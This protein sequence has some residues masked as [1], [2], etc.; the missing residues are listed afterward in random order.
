MISCDRG[1]DRD[2]LTRR[3]AREGDRVQGGETKII[4][5]FVLRGI[6]L[7]QTLFCAVQY[8]KAFLIARPESRRVFLIK[9][10]GNKYK[11]N[12]LRRDRNLSF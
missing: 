10:T 8:I 4:R 1:D 7:Q 11:V 9:K 5:S 3:V 6:V 2:R 12:I